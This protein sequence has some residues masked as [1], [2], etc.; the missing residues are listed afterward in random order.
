MKTLQ[1]V[2]TITVALLFSACDSTI[3]IATADGNSTTFDVS[4]SSNND[5]NTTESPNED[6]NTTESSNDD[7][8]TTTDSQTQL[9]GGLAVVACSTTN[10]NAYSPISDGEILQGENSDTQVK[11]ILND[12]G[13][14]SVCTLSGKAYLYTQN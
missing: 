11:I 3:T 2:L 14:K 13:T 10:D 9:T 1:I 12:D 4:T 5:S 8:N 7:T 6:S